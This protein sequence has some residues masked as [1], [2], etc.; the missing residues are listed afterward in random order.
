MFPE[1]TEELQDLFSTQ[2]EADTRLWLH[3]H[4]AAERFGTKTAIIWSPDTDVLVIGI[5][6]FNDIE[7]QNIWFKTGTKKNI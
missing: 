4:D 1:S 2:D 3:V 7:I 5:H 6:F